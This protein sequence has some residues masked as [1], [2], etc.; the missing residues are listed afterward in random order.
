MSTDLLDIQEQLRKELEAQKASLPTAQA[1]R[2]KT[3][4]KKFTLPGGEPQ[5]GPMDVIVV[6]W[7]F[8]N[9]YFEGSYNPNNI[10]PA[11]CHSSGRVEAEMQPHAS[12]TKS[13]ADTCQECPKN[14]WGSSGKNK[15]CKNGIR[16][17]VIP[18]NPT[19]DTS[20]LVID[21]TP[22]GMTA[23]IK[24]VNLLQ[25]KGILPIQV[26]TEIDFEKTVDY[27]TLRFKADK[28]HENL[29][30]AFALRDAADAVLGE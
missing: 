8:T 10:Q 23:W 9:S 2:I 12:S 30:T 7:R 13:Q 17:A 11:V 21:V 14:Q 28:P 18:P 5:E 29:A 25:A 1:G 3:K 16:L 19:A 22:T 4:G 26:I 27:P 6:G 15:A 20:P 24:Y